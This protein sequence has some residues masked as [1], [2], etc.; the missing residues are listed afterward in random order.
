[1]RI[2]TNSFQS[3]GAHVDVNFR[4]YDTGMSE[5]SLR[6][7]RSVHCTEVVALRLLPSKC[8]GWWKPGEPAPERG[9]ELGAVH[10]GRS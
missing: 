10:V 4:R 2:G 1:V 3:T 7:G 5:Q 8:A 6:R 9:V